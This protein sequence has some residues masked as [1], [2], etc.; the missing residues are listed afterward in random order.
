MNIT[1]ECGFPFGIISFL[2]V[3][4]IGLGMVVCAKMK[5]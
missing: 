4:G 2:F 1:F 5:I 3:C